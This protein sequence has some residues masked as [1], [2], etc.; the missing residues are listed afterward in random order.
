MALFCRLQSAE[1]SFLTPTKP[2]HRKY[3]KPLSTSMC[4]TLGCT[5]LPRTILAPRLSTRSSIPAP[6]FAP[7]QRFEL[8][9]RAAYMQLSN[10]CSCVV[11][12]RCARN[13][14]QL[15]TNALAEGACGG[16]MSN[17]WFGWLH[18]RKRLSWHRLIVHSGLGALAEKQHG[19]AERTHS[20]PS[21]A[22]MSCGQKTF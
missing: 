18:S 17:S 9:T 2:S 3:G 16:R 1:S 5:S 15:H 20:G 12:R 21:Q 7:Q 8:R 4:I 22:H 14:W 10:L 19:G 6:P 13:I 11:I